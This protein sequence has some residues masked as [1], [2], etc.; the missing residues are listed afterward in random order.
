MG[1]DGAYS[2]ESSE[3]PYVADVR[4]FLEK[5]GQQPPL[6]PREDVPVSGDSGRSSGRPNPHALALLALA[7]DPDGVGDMIFF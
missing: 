7:G 4:A 3:G 5:G 6:S 1:K 2:G